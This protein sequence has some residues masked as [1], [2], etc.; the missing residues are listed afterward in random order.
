LYADVAS[1]VSSTGTDIRQMELKA[2]D[3]RALGAMMVEVENLTHLQQIVKAVRRVKG[4]S[5]VARRERIT[6][7]D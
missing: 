2:V 1:A 4:I 7:E 5:E 6:A 3:G